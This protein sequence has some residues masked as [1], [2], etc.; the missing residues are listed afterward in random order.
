MLAAA[1]RL[2]LRLIPKRA[3]VPVLSGPLRGARWI[4]GAHTHGCWIGTYE[5]EATAAL[6]PYLTPGA[7]FW[8]L[9]AHAGYFA[10]LA[11]WR[12]C[13]VVAVEP[14][15]RNVHYLR[16]HFEL[17]RCPLTL[18]ESALSDHEGTER[19]DT[20]AGAAFAEIADH[21]QPVPCT[22]LDALVYR[23]GHPIPTVMKVDIEGS[24]ARA[25][26]GA[27]RVLEQARPVVLLSKHTQPGEEAE[28][29]LR[30]LGYTV[31]AL[32]ADL[33]LAHGSTTV[34]R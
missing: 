24:E 27:R 29:I 4:V 6:L 12:G 20:H 13:R 25:F 11:A 15:P 10:L 2:P 17:N 18:V 23:E 32:A 26:R 5:P 28:A 30:G 9:G 16:R 31:Q 8:D 33:V 1:L 7:V 19:L 34:Q 22:T 14:L 3:V 21:G